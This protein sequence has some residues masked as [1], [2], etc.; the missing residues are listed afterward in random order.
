MKNKK[1][2]KFEPATQSSFFCWFF[3]IGITECSFP[4]TTGIIVSTI[5]M[6]PD[7]LEAYATLDAE[8]SCA[9]EELH[10][11]AMVKLKVDIYG[12]PIGKALVGYRVDHNNTTTT[13]ASLALIV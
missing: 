8:P 5:E 11:S 10:E 13:S 7:L 12:D 2:A 4:F 1:K 9:D 6:D 3:S